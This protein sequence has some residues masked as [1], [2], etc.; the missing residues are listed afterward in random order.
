MIDIESLRQYK[1][2]KIIGHPHSDFDSMASGYLLEHIFIHLGINAEFVLQD[3]EVD[4]FFKE[5]WIGRHKTWKKREDDVLFLVD[6]TAS[7]DLPVIGCFDHHPELVHIKQ[8]YINEPKTSCA[9]V[10]YD[11]AESVGFKVPRSLVTLVIY[12]CYMDSLSFK[13]TKARPEDLAWCREKMR[14]YDMNEQ[15]VASFG[16]G[17]TPKKENYYEYICNGIKT[18][19]FDS[20]LIKSSYVVVENDEDDFEEIA[21][22][23]SNELNDDVVAWVFIASNVKTDKTRV[24]LVTK[25][26]HLSQTVNKLLS[27]AKDIIPA[28]FTFLSFR[29]DGDVTKKLIEKN[30]QIATMES[31]TSGLIASNITDY[32]GASAILKGSSITYSNKAKMMAGVDKKII[33]SHGVYSAETAKEMAWNARRTFTSD[34][35]IG[36]TGSFGN[37]DPSNPDSVAG[38]VYYQILHRWNEE[39]VKLVWKDVKASRKDMKQKTV[40]VVLATLMTMLNCW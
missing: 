7:Y 36:I 15:E 30:L 24:L 16:Y 4:E 10:I 28:I 12:S 17:L 25:E 37:V 9:K 23:L 13:S 8:N 34:V 18:Y 35:G 20:S 26:Y 39:P 6:H 27:R 22:I 21:E 32:E 19:Q 3:G 40:N 5:K 1:S 14:E 33:E 38:E 31:C 29:N 11:W 2:I